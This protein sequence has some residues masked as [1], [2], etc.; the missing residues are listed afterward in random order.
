MPLRIKDQMDDV[1]RLIVPR[2]S[3]AE[4]DRRWRLE[5]NAVFIFQPAVATPDGNKRLYWGD[6]VVCA[7][8]GA[9]RLGKRPIQAIEIR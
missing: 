6:C 8:E 1:N 7:P 4:R 2:F 5:A 9:R 3:L